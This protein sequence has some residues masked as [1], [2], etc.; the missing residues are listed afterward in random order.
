MTSQIILITGATSGIGRHAALYLA[1][2]GHRVIATGRKEP[3]LA[4]L[5]REASGAGLSLSTVALDV[6]RPGDIAAAVTEVARLTE[7][8]GVDVLVNNAG[9]GMLVPL[10]DMSDADT[11]ALFETNVF[12]LMA[13]TRAFLPSMRSRGRGR[14][15][16]ISSIGGIV[17]LPFYGAYSATKFAVESLS[18]AMRQELRPFGIRVVLVEPGPIRTEFN[19]TSVASLHRY[20][21]AA[22]PYAAL[23]PRVDKIIQIASAKAASPQTISRLIHKAVSA[24]RPR[25]RYVGPFTSRLAIFLSKFLPTCLLD[26]GMRQ[27][28]GL[29]RRHVGQLPSPRDLLPRGAD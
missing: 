10:D 7:G 12:G 20:G 1:Q 15:I 3:L 28:F 5:R 11:R 14:I 8:H 29:T 4:E 23:Y 2:R 19:R 27:V 25:A 26:F 18:D 24:G 13:V 16:N 21:S 9:H 22:S 17:T 6:T